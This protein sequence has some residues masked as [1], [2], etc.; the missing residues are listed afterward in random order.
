VSNPTLLYNGPIMQP[1]TDLA[2]ALGDRAISIGLTIPR[3]STVAT[4]Q[5]RAVPKHQ[6]SSCRRAD[7][8]PVRED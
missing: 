3:S 8:R 2:A 1:E 7:I 4:S 6:A 5:P